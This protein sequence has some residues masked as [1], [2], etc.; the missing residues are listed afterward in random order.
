[1]AT[2]TL[3]QL[4]AQIDKLAGELDK[5]SHR[6]RLLESYY[7][8]ESPLPAA[9]TSAKVTQA[10]R[11][12]MPVSDAPWGSLVVGSVLDRLEVGGI[13]DENSKV[14]DEVWGVWQ[15]NHM[16]SESKL[17]HCSGLISGR[18]FAL[19]WPDQ[20]TG[21]PEISLDNSSQMIVQ[22]AE[23]SRHK[24]VAALRR[25]QD[26]DTGATMATLYRPDGIYKF[27]QPQSNTSGAGS[28][29]RGVAA[30]VQRMVPGED[31]PVANPFEVVPVVEIRFN[32]QLKPGVFGYARGEY[33][34]CLGLIDRINLLTFLGLVVA[35]WMGFPIRAVI[36]DRILRDDDGNVIE[37]FKATADSVVQFE[38]PGVKL[39][40][41]QAADR[42]N[43]S[44]YPELA[45][46]A[47]IT[48]TPRHYFPLAQ[49]MANLSADAIRADEGA[50]NAKV[51]DH[52]AF[53]GEGW[54]EVLRLC[55]VMIDQQLSPRAE[56]VWLD[57]ESRSLAERADAAI[58]L[59]NIMP[60]QVLAERVLNATQDEIDRWEVL[61]AGDA[62]TQLVAA[63]KQPATASS[64]GNTP[65][66]QPAVTPA[67]PPG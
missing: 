40:T 31:W 18:T 53:A 38:D 12:L 41:F 39:D 47:A 25:W 29:G 21:R 59:N 42:S 44:V 62:L 50:L 36:G 5:R 37:P 1:M 45:H 11:R 35:F 57:H 20:V 54:E 8:G 13:R 28:D 65:D 16:D 56:L 9:V 15:E 64:N 32:P 7:D 33:A 27:E 48:K 49:A 34:H 2:P 23:G 67:A 51:T 4:L 52:K 14:A 61:K 6:Q 63:A 30:W 55:G 3:A 10:Y 46:L 17:G 58:K 66:N 43:L 24:R 22:Y 60:W 26:S 19:V